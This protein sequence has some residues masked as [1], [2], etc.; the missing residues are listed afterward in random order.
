MG[1]GIVMLKKLIIRYI[2]FSQAIEFRPV[3]TLPDAQ[4]LLIIS[5]REPGLPTSGGKNRLS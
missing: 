5:S 3:K 1:G 2:N 4:P